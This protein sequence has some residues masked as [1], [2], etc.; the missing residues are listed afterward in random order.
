[1]AGFSFFVSGTP[2]PGGSKNAF[3]IRR[4]G[5]P[6]GR[7]AVTDA[8]GKNGKAWRQAVA[9]AARQAY[10]GPPLTGP[11]R[12]TV[13]FSMPR[14]RNHYRSGRFSTLLKPGAPHWH[15]AKPDSLK[16]ARLVEDSLTGIAWVDDSQ[17]VLE[18][19]AKWYHTEPGAWVTVEEVTS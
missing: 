15:I 17:I 9:L 4:N 13:R 6:T 16:L 1:M 2:R 18:E 10:Q 5:I 11:V 19:L 14:P 3:A 7:V 8:S 12:L